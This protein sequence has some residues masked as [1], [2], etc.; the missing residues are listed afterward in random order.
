VVLFC[1]TCV[2][3]YILILARLYQDTAPH[4]LPKLEYLKKAALDLLAGDHAPSAEEIFTLLI[5]P[6]PAHLPK[7]STL[8]VAP[9]VSAQE[10][11]E[12][13]KRQLQDDIAMLRRISRVDTY[14]GVDCKAVLQSGQHWL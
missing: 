3:R 4:D 1:H 9:S 14:N 13:V 12:G 7:V 11:I 6:L 5:S 8:P 2:T 10:A